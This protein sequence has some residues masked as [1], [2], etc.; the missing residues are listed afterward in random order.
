MKWVIAAVLTVWLL[1]SGGVSAQ[2][3]EELYEEQLAASGSRELIHTLP[4][5]T[6]KLLSR[7]GVDT[8]DSTSLTEPDSDRWQEVLGEVISS[9]LQTPLRVA[10]TVLAAVLLYAWID[11]LRNTLHADETLSVFGT[12]CVL[13]LSGCLLVPL[14]QCIQQVSE[15]MTS[16]AV[17]MGSFTPVYAGILL[18]DG[19]A[20]AALSFQSLVLYAAQLLSWVAGTVLV[21]LMTAAL[22]LGVTGSVTPRIKLGRAGKL[23]NKAAVWLL[24]LGMLL[25]TGLLSLQ[26]LVGSAADTVG[27]RAAKFSIASLVPVVGG[28]LSEMFATVRGCLQLLRSTVGGFGLLA[29]VLIVLPPLC[30]CCGWSVLLAVCHTA[31]DMLELS[32]LP[33]VLEAARSTVRSLIGVL[34]ACASLL[35]VAVTVVTKAA[36]G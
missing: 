31:A 35:I 13:A 23:L 20:S 14:M 12:V 33:A 29:T 2:T 11:G 34:C 19:R 10:G 32:A 16:V 24:S 4:D 7:L 9:A 22:A 25:F 28:S 30:S 6:Q 3:V 36:G 21:P 26:T 8:L 27:A 18:T 1:G 5:A 15:A 17:F